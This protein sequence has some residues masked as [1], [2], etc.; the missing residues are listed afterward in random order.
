MP[1]FKSEQSI[2]TGDPNFAAAL[3]T[4]GCPPHDPPAQLISSDNG[5]DYVTFRLRDTALDGTPTMMLSAAWSDPR[6]MRDLESINHGF[7]KVCAFSGSKPKET[8]PSREA[9]IA[10]LAE[11]CGVTI[12][13]A[14]S[15]MQNVIQICNASPESD[16]AYAAAFITNRFD[17]LDNAK[18]AQR[19]GDIS[20][21]MNHGGGF[22]L[23]SENLPEKQRQYLLRNR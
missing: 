18:E 9:W 15:A 5:R 8:G 3:M 16:L 13:A 6:A 11:Y 19:N 7:P 17:L 12:D 14:F 2:T 20:I 21:F 22:S 1:I 4:V 23:I 10:H